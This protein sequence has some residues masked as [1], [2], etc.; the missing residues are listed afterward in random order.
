MSRLSTGRIKSQIYFLLPKL[1]L[2]KLWIFFRARDAEKHL[3]LPTPKHAHNKQGVKHFCETLWG[4][5]RTLMFHVLHS[6]HLNTLVVSNLA[7]F[8]IYL[9][10]SLPS[11]CNSD[12]I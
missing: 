1:C 10:S 8:R 9:S 7:I 11:Q 2:D 3:S 12:K 6:L 5:C 4:I